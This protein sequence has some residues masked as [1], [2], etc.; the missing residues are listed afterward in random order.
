MSY[1]ASLSHAR[2]PATG[3]IS[4]G[5]AADITF[6]RPLARRN[7]AAQSFTRYRPAGG[8]ARVD[9]TYWSRFPHRQEGGSPFL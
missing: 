9:V 5:L 6:E 3:C 2:R 7:P 1:Q 8:A 4:Q